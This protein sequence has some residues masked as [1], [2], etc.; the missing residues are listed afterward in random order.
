VTNDIRGF[1]ALVDDVPAITDV[2]IVR[3]RSR[4]M[5]SSTSPIMR[6]EIANKFADLIVT[7]RDM[8]DVLRIARAAARVRMPL[9]MRGAGTCNFGQG[10]PLKGG[11]IV[12]MTN[13]AEV[14]WA[15]GGRV[16]A[17]AG[18]R[19]AAID[20]ATRPSGLELRIHPS[21]RRVSTIAG[22]PASMKLGPALLGER[23]WRV[24]PN[25]GWTSFG[26]LS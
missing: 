2:A 24:P 17:Q 16:R 1:L 21:T 3:R 20:D 6:R 11:A 8:A 4:D 9:M 19:M 14:L 5:S 22:T 13:L 23:V 15:R 26:R 25:E 7:P 18:A 12:D 10:V